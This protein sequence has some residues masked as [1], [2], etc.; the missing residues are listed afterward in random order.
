MAKV[1]GISGSTVPNSA[2]DGLIKVAMEATGMEQHAFIKLVDC[3]IA[4]CRGCTIHHPDWGYITPCHID[5][6][7]II[8]DDWQEIAQKMKEADAI[9]FGSN[10]TLY[11]MNGISKL[12]IE[13]TICIN[14]ATVSKDPPEIM[15]GKIGAVVVVCNTPD[16]GRKTADYIEMW[17]NELMMLSVGDIIIQGSW[18]C[19]FVYPCVVNRKAISLTYGNCSTCE[20]V[21]PPDPPFN[22]KY[23]RIRETLKDESV[24]EQAR[25]L[26]LKIKTTYHYQHEVEWPL[27]KSKP[28]KGTKLEDGGNRYGTT[29]NIPAMQSSK[30]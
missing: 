19:P 8:K 13:R 25:R 4:P 2:T 1:V 15:A 20:V 9:I 28:P 12:F 30:K 24:L 7:C 29:P 26:G 3:K 6:E 18:G 14:H 10:P 11:S 23:S 5:N 27:V 22:E 17:Y 21:N 16:D